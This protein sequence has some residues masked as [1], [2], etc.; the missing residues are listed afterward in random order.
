M[1]LPDAAEWEMLEFEIEP[2]VVVK[3]V[4][5]LD[6]AMLGKHQRLSKSETVECQHAR[7]LA[8][9]EAALHWQ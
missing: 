7:A 3:F 1:A 8:G 5:G 4:S 9:A 2:V 6:G